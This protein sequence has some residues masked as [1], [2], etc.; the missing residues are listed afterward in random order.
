MHFPRISI[1]F[2]Q[3]TSILGLI[4]ISMYNDNTFIFLSLTFLT[5]VCF[6]SPRA[7]KGNVYVYIHTGWC[8]NTCNFTYSIKITKPP[9][10]IFSLWKLHR[11]FLV[12]GLCFLLHQFL[13]W[14]LF[15]SLLQSVDR[16]NLK[17]DSHVVAS[18]IIR[19]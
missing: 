13:H 8:L 1:F 17:K 3:G 6:K 2:L 10:L 4:Q 12:T 18:K 19:F 15:L 5:H 14:F 16:R 11:S 9:L 7:F